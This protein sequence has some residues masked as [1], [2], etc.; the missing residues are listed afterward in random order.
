MN[1]VLG[2]MKDALVIVVLLIVAFVAAGVILAGVIALSAALRWW[3]LDWRYGDIVA[4]VV[5]IA[6]VIWLILTFLFYME[7]T[8]T[9]C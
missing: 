6:L 3:L 8:R 2:A 1:K 7:R 4:T 5:P 9:K